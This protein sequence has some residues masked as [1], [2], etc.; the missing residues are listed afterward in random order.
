MGNPSTNN[1]RIK[2][3]SIALV[4]A[5]L[6]A[7]VSFAQDVNSSSNNTVITSGDSVELNEIKVVSA[8]GFEQSIAD[9]PAT[10][11]VITSEELQKKSYN[12]V[13][14]ALKNVPGVFVDG[15]GSQQTV[16]MRGLSSGY[17]LFLVDGKPMQGSDAF[18][19]NGQLSG[20]QMN[21]LPPIE[22]IERIEVIRG[23]ASSLYGSD[24]M[25]GVINIITKKITNEWG[26]GITMEYTKAS[27]SNKVNN[28][29]F[30]T[31][32]YI[33]APLIDDV[34]SL[35]VSGSYLNQDES[36]YSGGDDNTESDPE[37]K[38]KNLNTKLIFA[39][40]DRDT[41]TAG[42]TYNLQERIQTPG[43]SLADNATESEYYKT[44]KNNYFVTHEGKYGD[45]LLNSYIN[46][47]HA[48]NPT[49]VG[50]VTGQGI[51]FE[52]LTLN[53]QGTYFFENN[54]L[55]IGAN[56]K[57]EELED[58]GTS[59]TNKV[60]NMERYQYSFFAE[61]EWSI[62]DDLKLTISGRFDKNEN[63][64]SHFSP[65]A[66]L[67]YHVTN[68]LTLKGG[69]ISGYKAPSL[70]QSAPDYTGSSRGGVTVGN[71]DLEPETSLSYEFGANYDN[72]DL[73]ILASIVV[74]RTDFEDKIT[75]TPRICDPNTPCYYQGTWYPAHQFGYTAYEN[76]DE[77][78]VNGIEHTLDVQILSNLR[79]RH[80]YTYTDSEQKSG[81]YKGNPLT[82]TPRH[83]FNAGL[84][85]QA[86]NKLE[87]WTQANYRG[88]V[89]VYNR[90]GVREGT[91][92][93]YTF[94]DVGLVYQATK[95]LSLK[96]GVYNL[97]NKEVTN[98]E[99][100]YVLDGRK[101]SAAFSYR[102]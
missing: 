97:F 62:L 4:A 39:L 98:E 81:T 68:D 86:T 93:A 32:A 15:G 52:T 16:L 13:T 34:L 49:R 71:P 78:E 41:L 30:S 66:Y 50:A 57:N 92:D 5:S 43:K 51:E 90:S 55:S 77:V 8:S 9:A 80:S 89:P 28:D 48:K 26:G 19:L 102:F 72:K 99:Y 94:V 101:F 11:T 31:S 60:V 96:F 21:F 20:A 65:K 85:W 35:Q 70:R 22:A 79:Y 14:D 1:K 73:G 37:F 2:K 10:M 74:Y 23:P 95:D 27:K 6:L 17:T 12:D 29:G 69:V 88:E 45:F 100:S 56:F 87:L 76:V 59:S 82:D 44:I 83:M 63:F 24:A 75:R 3:T 36:D 40:T 47:D 58:G 64:G 42:Y 38:R 53:T 33:N 25:G 84:D 61:D 91:D 54:I 67:V 18:E 7:Q 46:Y